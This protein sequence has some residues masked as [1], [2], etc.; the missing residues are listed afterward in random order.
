MEEKGLMFSRYISTRNVTHS[1]IAIRLGISNVPTKRQLD[2]LKH[3]ADNFYDSLVEK[4]GAAPSITS[5]YRNRALNTAINGARNSDHMVLGDVA[6][7]DIKHGNNVNLFFFILEKL[8]FYKL[9]AEFPIDGKPSWVHISFSTDP[10]KNRMKKVMVARKKK[11]LEAGKWVNRTV[12]T[13]FDKNKNEI[14]D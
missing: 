4:Y 5:F 12:Y 10:A 14:Y 8:D 3:L 1:D 6:A 13:N 2:I 9:I 11:V 7:I